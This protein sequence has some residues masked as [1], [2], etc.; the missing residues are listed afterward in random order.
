MQ[1]T[2]FT[3]YGLRTLMYLASNPQRLCSVK[4][5]SEYHDISRNHLV[6]IVLRLVEAGYISSFKGKGGG[7]QLAKPSNEIQLGEVIKLLEPN[8]TMVECFDPA[9]NTC[10]ITGSCN[11]KHYL[12]EASQSF[13]ESMNKHTLEDAI[14]IQ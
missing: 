12:Y 8:M 7:M 2:K 13:I 3:D 5:V 10:R 6:K 14:L 1:L 4:E 9:T 11:V